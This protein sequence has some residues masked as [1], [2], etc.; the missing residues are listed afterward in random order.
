MRETCIYR[1]ILTKHRRR[2]AA[3]SALRLPGR[4][5]QVLG[6]RQRSL[7]SLGGSRS[8]PIGQR[9]TVPPARRGGRRSVL[10]GPGGR[11]LL[12]RRLRTEIGKFLASPSVGPDDGCRNGS[13][14]GTVRFR[15][16]GESM[17]PSK[18]P[19]GVMQQVDPRRRAAATCSLPLGD[20]RT[21]W[22][23]V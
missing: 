23:A 21:D 10:A 20:V 2:L 3:S 22:R 17:R 19:V 18:K 7:S 1:L 5:P 15:R 12:A 9:A 13:E 11:C 16:E 4:P 8:L 14:V 6:T